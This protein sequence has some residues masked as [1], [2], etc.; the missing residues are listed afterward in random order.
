MRHGTDD[1]K[2]IEASLIAMGGAMDLPL[3]GTNECFFADDGMYEGH[4]ALL[5]IAGGTYISEENRRRVTPEHRFKSAAEMRALFAD[6][7]DAI[8]NTLV[9]ARRCG[10][11]LRTR[12]PLLPAFETGAGRSEDEELRAQ[13]CEGLEKRLTEQVFTP[14]MD[15]AKLVETRELYS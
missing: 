11:L 4:D 5:C 14:D 9:I 12:N 13:A 3:V 7:P 8:D 2:R 10:F 6:L 15:E 1:E